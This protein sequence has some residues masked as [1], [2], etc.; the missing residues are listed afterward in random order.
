MRH[1]IEN[2]VRLTIYYP[3]HVKLSK[4]VDH[5]NVPIPTVVLSFFGP[6]SSQSEYLL[7]VHT[8]RRA[9]EYTLISF[10]NH[11]NRL[12]SR[13]DDKKWIYNLLI[14]SRVNRVKRL[15]EI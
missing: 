3:R 4:D 7:H 10:S 1:Y 5:F 12:P 13:S 2:Q 15:F 9:L 8:V 11:S 14:P 6:E